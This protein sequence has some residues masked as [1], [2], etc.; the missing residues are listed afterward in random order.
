VDDQA[1][2]SLKFST[3]IPR[4]LARDTVSQRLADQQAVRETLDAPLEAATV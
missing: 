3:A 2:E 4:E 1:I